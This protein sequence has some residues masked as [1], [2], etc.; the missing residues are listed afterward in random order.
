[1]V[2]TIFSGLK[3]E[4]ILQDIYAT[5]F[6]YNLRQLLI[7]ESQEIVNEQVIE[8]KKCKHKQKVNKNVALGVLKPKIM[9]LFLVQQPEKIIEELIK[10]F[11]RNKVPTIENK[12]RPP[13]KKNIAKRR[14]LVTQKN[15][16][17][18]I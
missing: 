18:A 14:N 16:K 10:C 3:P 8:S 15:Y 9:T 13:R 4:A 6:I 11:A 17:K 7:N 5:L 2:L 12:I 1:M